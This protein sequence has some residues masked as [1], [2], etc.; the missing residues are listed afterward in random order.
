MTPTRICRSSDHEAH[1]LAG[2]L[3]YYDLG[4]PPGTFPGTGHVARR[5]SIPEPEE[6][7]L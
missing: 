6:S 4:V 7:A 1:L 2:S 3:Q 5:S